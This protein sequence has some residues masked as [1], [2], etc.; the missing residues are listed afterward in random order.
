MKEQSIMK[1]SRARKYFFFHAEISR[2]SINMFLKRVEEKK[3]AL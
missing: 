2:Y 3:Y 1:I